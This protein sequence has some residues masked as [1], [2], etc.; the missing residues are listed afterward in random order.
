MTTG[1][2]LY[3]SEAPD[4]ERLFYS[5]AD[6]DGL[7]T[8]SLDGGEESLLLPDLA[9]S[10]WG[11]WVATTAGLYFVERARSGASLAHWQE[12]TAHVTWRVDLARAPL[13]PGLTVSMDG[14]RALI[15]SLDR[16]ESDLWRARNFR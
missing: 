6:R 3:A 11:N 7:W 10:D 4:G 15:A 12:A 8:V 13:N 1:G 9:A 5:R 16:N 14:K 2:G